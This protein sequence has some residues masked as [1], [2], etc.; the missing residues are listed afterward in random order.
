MKVR[1]VSL[2]KRI[3]I[4]LGILLLIGDVIIGCVIYNKVQSL[5][6]KQVQQ[7]AI[8]LAN[9]AA[10][11]I[12]ENMFE[13]I[14][15]TSDE[16]YL[17][18]LDSLR[19]FKNNTTLEYVYTF[20]LDDQGQPVFAVDADEEEP[21]E[22][23]EEYG[24]MLAGMT[25]AFS[26]TAAADEEPSSDE[27]GTYISAYSPI[28]VGEKVVGIT[29]VDV[30]YSSIQDSIHR[31]LRII[32]AIC[33]VVF[34][35]LFLVLIR[36]GQKMNSGFTALNDKI[37][38]L[39][40]G[41]GDLHKKINIT[42][43]DEFEV[44]GNSINTFI[45]QLER[46]IDQVAENSNGNAKGIRDINNNTLEISANM[47]ECSASTETVSQQLEQTS[48]NV[49]DLAHEIDSVS[50][51]VLEASVRARNA[52]ELAVSHKLQSEDEIRSIQRDIAEMMEQAK[53]VEQVQK[54]NEE[55]MEIVNQTRILSINAQI[56][57]AR[58][59]EFGRGFA[60]VAK[61]VAKLS[62]DIS[63]SV[64]D[65]GEIN[66]QVLEAMKH[67]V[68]YLERMTRYLDDSVSAD[69]EAFAEIGKDYGETTEFIQNQMQA[70]KDQS[71]EI[72]ST[73][74]VVSNSINDISRAV[75]DS[76]EQIEDLC[77]STVEMSDG[78][79]RLLEI[80]ILKS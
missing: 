49:D 65:I 43:G 66:D 69:Y 70:I 45:S 23:G 13:A 15:E 24:E 73:V 33:I 54:I 79:D 1:K 30:S 22:Y 27:W 75:S 50:E 10:A 56:E 36:I 63:L 76:A 61:Q 9:C 14:E 37:I 42:S 17:G 52:A 8:D 51:S 47:E 26:G 44:V 29:G 77:D 80:E 19:I 6:I 71:A 53:A 31:L 67:M 55:I 35:I 11:T 46:L 16:N 39:A 3:I 5:F 64:V 38:E 40:D 62:E 41:S 4:I 12:D 68:S 2:S 34:I 28:M 21:A 59:G 25:S 72:A 48:K 74:A 18:V 60:V 7:S 57:A 78:I 32:V 20:K 58:A